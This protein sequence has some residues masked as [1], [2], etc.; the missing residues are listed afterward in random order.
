MPNVSYML[1][2]SEDEIHIIWA[3]LA[4]LEHRPA[5]QGG[6]ELQRRLDA[7]CKTALSKVQ[8][9]MEGK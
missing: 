9:L 3:S 4:I 6:G 1:E 5:L 8:R 2:L 7:A